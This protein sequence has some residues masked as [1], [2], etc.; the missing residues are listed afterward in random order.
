ME[1]SKLNRLP[2]E[3]ITLIFKGIPKIQKIFLNK[4]YYTQFNYLIDQIIGTRYDSYIRDMVRNNYAF[5]FQYVLERNFEKWLM[6][7][8]Y[9]YK[10]SIYDNYICFLI[11]FSRNNNAYKC[12]NLLNDKLQLSRL[13]KEWYKNN[14]VKYNKWIS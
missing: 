1:L 12:S 3:L 13:K 2:E 4:Y 6:V 5:T 8:N 10:Q 14:R 9:H 11:E 7:T